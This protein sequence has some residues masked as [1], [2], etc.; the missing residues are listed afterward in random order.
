MRCRL[1]V[2]YAQ[3]AQLR[4]ATGD[5]CDFRLDPPY[6]KQQQKVQL[7]LKQKGNRLIAGLLLAYKSK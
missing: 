7:L 6:L 4:L 5:N 1:V 3:A 2:G